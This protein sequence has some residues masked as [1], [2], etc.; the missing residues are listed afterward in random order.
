MNTVN[1]RIKNIIDIFNNI[2]YIALKLV[3]GETY[4]ILSS[5]VKKYNRYFKNIIY[6]PKNLSELYIWKSKSL[7]KTQ[8]HTQKSQIQNFKNIHNTKNILKNPY[9]SNIYQ[10]FW[11]FWI[12]HRFSDSDRVGSK[13]RGSSTTKLNKVKRSVRFLSEP[14]FF[15][16]IS[17]RFL[18]PNKMPRASRVLF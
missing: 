16:L 2:I 17:D 6:R 9:T 18:D 1:L 10:K 4:K 13:T 11:V 8:N 15:G 7:P 3:R 14:E 5:V 12:S